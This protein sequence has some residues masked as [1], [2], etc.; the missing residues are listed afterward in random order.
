[1]GLHK[2]QVC[3]WMSFSMQRGC[4]LFGGRL[5]SSSGKIF[6]IF[7]TSHISLI[8]LVEHTLSLVTNDDGLKHRPKAEWSVVY[9]NSELNDFEMW[10]KS[11][12]HDESEVEVPTPRQPVEK[13]FCLSVAKVSYGRETVYPNQNISERSKDVP[14]HRLV[15]YDLRGAWTKSNRNVAFALFDTF[16]KT[17]VRTFFNKVHAY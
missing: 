9:M 7:L 6:K 2:F 12:I 5:S 13:S 3:Y 10:L 14:T 11:A 15:V 17:T 8:Y 4:E 16:M 1:M